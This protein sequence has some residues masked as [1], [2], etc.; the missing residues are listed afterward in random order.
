MNTIETH[1][2]SLIGEDT[3]NPDVFTDDS[4]GME[5]IRDS[6]NDAIEEISIFTGGQ[7]ETYYVP[8]RKHRTFYRFRFTK[9]YLGWIT[10][11]W[12]VTQKRRLDQTSLIKIMNFNP[13][14]LYNTG[15][16]H[17]Y[18]PFGFN[19]FGMWPRPSSD[20]D[21]I[22]I[23]AMMIPK[24]YETD[25][26]RIKLRKNLE[27]AAAHFAVGEYYASR[28]DARK[29]IYHHNKYFERMGMNIKYPASNER[30]T[31]LTSNKDPWPKSSG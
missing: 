12:L 11:V 1:V 19:Y 3:E 30:Q 5:P 27:W 20:T 17:S 6:I 21:I 8:L 29:A 26:D 25:T 16:P 28:G 18:F 4:T 24:R 31:M 7:K 22:E 23:S 13:R 14:W 15:T 10:D 9:G 2:L